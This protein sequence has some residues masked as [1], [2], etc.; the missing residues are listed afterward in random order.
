IRSLFLYFCLEGPWLPPSMLKW[1][2]SRSV[3]MRKPTI[4]TFFFLL[5]LGVSARPAKA[6]VPSYDCSKLVQ[7]Y[8]DVTTG[9]VYACK[10]SGGVGTW[11][12]AGGSSCGSVVSNT[13]N[14]TS[15]PSD[16]GKTLSFNGTNITLTLPNPVPSSVWGICVSNL[17]ATS[18]TVSPNGLTLNGGGSVAVSTNQ[19]II[20]STDGTNYFYVGG[21]S[22]SSGTV[23]PEPQNRVPY[24]SSSGTASTLGQVCSPPTAN[25]TYSLLYSVTASAAVQPSCPEVGMTSSVIS[26]AA[27]TYTVAY[28][29]VSGQT[30]VHDIAG[31]QAVTVTLPTPTTLTNS[32]AVFRY[33]NHSAQSDTI[34]PTTWTIAKNTA[35]A[36][37]NISVPSGTAWL[38]YSGVVH[39]TTLD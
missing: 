7:V 27:T 32:N 35:A 4:I 38:V 15:V 1:P 8:T 37:A 29:D 19:G 23:T 5:F 11:V 9:N 17:A 2:E 24:Y 30:V 22:S 34:T 18:L 21:V 26:G 39:A 16:L 12:P 14:Y 33:S 3:G 10:I 20:I 6:Q 36:G 13:T 31:S 28:T 25:G